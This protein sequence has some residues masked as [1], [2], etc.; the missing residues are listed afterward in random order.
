[1]NHYSIDEEVVMAYE[2]SQEV[3]A[4]AEQVIGAAIEAHRHLGPGFQEATYHRAL[5]IELAL[6]KVPYCSE[7]PVS[8]L[9]KGESIGDGRIDLL[10]AD[11]LVIEL[12]ATEPKPDGFRR[13]VVAYL[14]ATGL[15]LG[16][17][18]NF[19]TSILKEGISRVV[20]SN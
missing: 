17:V 11:Q 14:K 20:H 2:P 16:L 18:I 13:Q 12:K 9:Y 15:N 5:M 6:R 3:N 1:V 7:V 19:N 4:L 10:I 8:M